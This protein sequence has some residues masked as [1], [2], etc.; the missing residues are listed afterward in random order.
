LSLDYQRQPGTVRVE[1][2]LAL[3]EVR[4]SAGDCPA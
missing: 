4:L 3:R 2:K 1:G